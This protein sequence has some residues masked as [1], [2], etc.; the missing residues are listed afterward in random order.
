MKEKPGLAAVL[1][2]NFTGDLDELLAGWSQ[3][4]PSEFT[5]EPLKDPKTLEADLAK[6]VLG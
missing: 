4:L 2:L 5:V 6:K 1:R 3:R